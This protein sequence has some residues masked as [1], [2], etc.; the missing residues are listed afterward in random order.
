MIVTC[1]IVPFGQRLLLLRAWWSVAVAVGSVFLR[2][3]SVKVC[4]GGWTHEC[5]SGVKSFQ[6]MESLVLVYMKFNNRRYEMRSL[7]LLTGICRSLRTKRIDVELPPLLCVEQNHK[8]EGSS[9]SCRDCLW[10]LMFNV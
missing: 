2:V 1:K 9:I 3:G 8:V 4:K 5:Y 7:T 6:E 10:L